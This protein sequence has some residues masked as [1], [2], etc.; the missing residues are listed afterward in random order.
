MSER[1]S[2]SQVKYWLDSSDENSKNVGEEGG[3]GATHLS[4]H[5]FV[6]L[7]VLGGFL[8]LDH[9]YLRS[10]W[11]FL[12]KCIVNIVCFG[13][14]WIYDAVQALFNP[15]VIRVY[16]LFLPGWGPIGVGAGVLSKE[17]P[18][19]KHY[20][21]LLY[22]FSL[23]F[24]GIIGMD[25]FLVGDKTTGFI[26]LLSAVSVLFLPIALLFWGY[27][28]FQFFI[29]TKDVVSANHEFFGAPAHSLSS[30]MRSRFPILSFLFSPVESLKYAINKVVGPA[31][32]EPITKTAQ[33]AI[34]TAEHAVSTVDHTVQLG[35]NVVSKGSDIVEQVGKT[36]DTLSQVSSFTPAASMYATAQSAL[37]QKG[38]FQ[39]NQPSIS[40]D[41]LNATGYF[42]LGTLCLIVLAGFSTTIYRIK[43]GS[44]REQQQQQ[45][46]D[47]TP[48]EPRVL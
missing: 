36:M 20:Q 21:F 10:P 40:P 13:I 32:I 16:G 46:R 17:E 39:S 37:G 43:N 47:D 6:G 9:L 2:V 15:D 28:V 7:S 24:G 27:N 35:R 14:W 23:I 29:N 19:K 34:D 30:Q 25:S 4:Y 18:D 42:L 5:T 26:R 41:N 33:A 11:T 1:S 38:G 12:A 22:A 8:G 44:Q 45:S 31:L 3:E 48:P